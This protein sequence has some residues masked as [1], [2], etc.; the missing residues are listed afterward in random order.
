MITN[1]DV[2]PYIKGIHLKKLP[3]RV[4]SNLQQFTSCANQILKGKREGLDTIT[5]EQQIDVMIYK[6]YDLTYDEVLLVEP[7]FAERM[8]REEYEILKVE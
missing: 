4:P 2:F 3:V 8:S 6:L 7:E 5:L 1:A